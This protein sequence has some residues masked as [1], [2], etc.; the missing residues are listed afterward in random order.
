MRCALCRGRPRGL[1]KTLCEECHFI[2]EAF[3]RHGPQTM[4]KEIRQTIKNMS[5]ASSSKGR[6]VS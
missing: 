1:G 3:Q 4:R 5:S 6:P 2:K